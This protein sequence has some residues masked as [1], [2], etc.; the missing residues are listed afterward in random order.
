MMKKY[1]FLFLV[2][3]LICSAISCQNNKNK[4]EEVEAYFKSG[5]ESYLKKG[6]KI[7]NQRIPY[8]YFNDAL[9]KYSDNEKFIEEIYE[10]DKIYDC[11]RKTTINGKIGIFN[12]Y[13]IY[14][15]YN[16]GIEIVSFDCEDSH[17]IKIPEKIGGK[18]V[19]KLGGNLEVEESIDGSNFYNYWNC[20]NSASQSKIYISSTVKEIVKGTFD[21]ETLERIEVDK[22]NPYYSSKDGILYDKSGKIR[23]CVPPNHHSRNK[24]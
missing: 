8:Y 24:D 14:R 23:L 5:I 15:E 13:I 12:N 17:D 20:F 16:N 9:E 1:I 19:I 11:D 22:N 7:N 18:K 6:S 10:Y 4:N 2:C 21:V 3:I